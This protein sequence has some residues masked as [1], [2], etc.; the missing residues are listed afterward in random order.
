MEIGVI[1]IT[2]WIFSTCFHEFG[3]AITAYWGGD[4]SV[5][6]KGYLTMNPIVYFNSATTLII[7]VLALML[8]GIPLPGAAV[9][10]NS[11]RIKSRM[12]L[13]LVSFA[14]PLFTLIMTILL[15]AFNLL[16]V[17][18]LK[19]TAGDDNLYSI[20]YTATNSLI[21][22]HIYVFYLNLLPLPPLDGFGILEPWLPQA[23]QRKARELSG[24]FFLVLIGLFWYVDGFSYA[25]SF[26]SQLSAELLGV[27]RTAAFAG[28]KSL[29][30]HSYPLI[31]LIVVAW[32][33]KSKMAPPEEKADSLMKEKKYE[34]ALVLYDEAL[35]KREDSR[36][37][38]AKATCLL[39][40]GRRQEALASAEKSI[41]IDPES[42]QSLG[43]AAACFAEIG[44]NDKALG[45][46]ES[47]IKYDTNENFPFTRFV[48]AS[49]LFNTG[50]YANA[51]ETVDEYLKREPKSIEGLFVKGNCLEMLNRYDEA[52]QIY[53]KAARVG[54]EGNIRAGLAKGILLCSLSQTEKGISEFEKFLPKDPDQR[55]AEISNLKTLLIE[56]A[57]KL[58]SAGKGS[59]ADAT[60][61]AIPQLK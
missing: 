54:P 11:S 58:D 16:V 56:T 44:E 50:D 53:D 18:T 40:L 13:S 15:I 14:G 19:G 27:D 36:L 31:G 9:S 5:K 3:H 7:P 46:A 51:L 41:K 4:K 23:V 32:I 59:M 60:R 10:I 55:Q 37:L 20:I 35:K 49:V 33:V 24:V 45:A 28:I 38:I 29:R 25:M 8:G 21:Y 34:E 1:I 48:K 6:D 42:A 30:A 57:V 39:S 12:V 47:A 61:N 26:L 22:L 52:L 43:I 17:P 2:V